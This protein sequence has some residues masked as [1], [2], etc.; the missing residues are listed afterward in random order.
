MIAERWGV[1]D[2]ERQIGARPL[3]IADGIIAAT[4]LERGLTLVM[5]NL[6]DFAGL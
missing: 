4:A 6:K 1:L 3:N 2:G 5:R